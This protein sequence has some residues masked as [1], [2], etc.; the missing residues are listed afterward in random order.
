MRRSRCSQPALL[1]ATVDAQSAV[2][3]VVKLAEPRTAAR[4]DVATTVVFLEPVTH[5]ARYARP[6]GELATAT[7]D[8]REREFSPHVQVVQAGGSVDFP[9][10]DPFS[11]N[12][13]SNTELGAFDLGLYRRGMTRSATFPA[14]S[15]YAI[16][17]NIHASMVSFV[18]AV[19]GQL[20]ARVHSD[21]AFT[22]PNVPAG[23]YVLHVWHERAQ[24]LAEPITI[25]ATG[26]ARLAVEVDTRTF[27]ATSHLNKFGQPYAA[28]GVRIATD[29][30]SM[31]DGIGAA[32][33]L[34]LGLA[35]R[36]FT[37][38]IVI[39]GAVVAAALF[40]GS[41]SLR[42]ADDEANR[43]GLDQSADIVAQLL[44]GRERNLAGGARVFVQH[45]YF[46]NVLVT[47]RRRDD[48]IDQSLEAA[49]QLDAHW[50]M[51]TDQR[52]ILL[53]KSDEPLLA[54]DSLG[55]VPLVSGALAGGVTS[56]FGV[57]R[58]T[59]LF[60]AVGLP[61]VIPGTR[62]GR[63]PR[64]DAHHRLRLRRRREV[65]RCG[66]AGVLRSR[67]SGRPSTRRIDVGPRRRCAC[68]RRVDGTEADGQDILGSHRHDS[69]GR[70]F[71]ADIAADHRRW[72][73]R[74]RVHG[75]ALSARRGD[76]RKQRP[77]LARHRRRTR[78][79]ARHPLRLLLGASHRS[80]AACAVVGRA[81]RGGRRLR[82]GGRCAQ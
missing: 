80:A 73:R 4:R 38:T 26:V 48:L 9:N 34:A 16:Y 42:R 41:A 39:V 1:P 66:G 12:V 11:H 70:L 14:T 60:Q 5:P 49:T 55:S 81:S 30:Q 72:R 46:R 35:A 36:V 29:P 3:G 24:E 71:R 64:R 31:N 74:R 45:P 44:V 15:V 79:A 22:I 67:W 61:I 53:A 51:I 75:A 52:G 40:I 77:I 23:S 28:L 6:V 25:P 78:A 27:P 69:R 47:E 20:Y 57:S 82:R 17:C 10:M 58:D 59:L 54:V 13:F 2:S 8:M 76:W 7:I 43:R 19:P 33:L 37:S 63:R 68:R 65:G 56:G 18:I 32:T 50:V 21:G 62:S